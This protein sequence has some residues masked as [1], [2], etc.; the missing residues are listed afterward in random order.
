MRKPFITLLLC[1]TYLAGYSQVDRWQQKVDYTMEIDFDDEKHQYKGKQLLTYTNNS[2]DTLK[3]VFYHLYL[4]AFQPNSM[5]DVRSRTIEDA[6]PR[7][8]DRI[9]KLK[10][11]EVGYQKVIS[12][13]QNKKPV[14]YHVEGTVLEVTLKEPIAPKK[15]AT[16][17]MAFEA[18]V[19][20]QI[21]RT[22]RY[23]KEGVAYSMAQWYPKLAEYDFQGWHA[24][25]YVGREFY[26]VWGDFDVKIKMN[27]DF[28]V[29]ATG[30]IQ[31]PKEVGHGYNKDKKGKPDEDGKLTWHFKAPNVHDFTWAADPD[32]IHKIVKASYGPEMHFFWKKGQGIDD[33]WEKLPDYMDKT[34]KYMN[35][36][37]GEYPYNVYNFVQGGDGGMEYGMLTLVTGQRGL[38]SLVGVSIHELVHSWFQFILATNESLYCWMDEGFDSYTCN[39]IDRDLLGMGE[40]VHEGSYRGYYFIVESGKEEPLNTHSDHF[41]YNRSYGIAAYSKGAIYLHQ[42]SYVVGK[43]AFDRGMK[44]YFNTWKMRH[45]NADDF[46]LIM[47]KESGLQLDWYNEYFV[48]TTK[49]IDYAIKD[50]INKDSR[51]YVTLE[52]LGKMPMPIDLE[53]EYQ[54]GSK[55]V[56]YIPLAIMRG[57]KQSETTLKRTIL[58]DWA[59]THPLYTLEIPQ[60]KKVKYI[61]IDKSKRMADIERTNN[62]YRIPD[63]IKTGAGM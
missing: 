53:I 35:E 32:Y 39:E 1:L 27:K 22:G 43:S 51:T 2:P 11:E 14:K 48:N 37:Y 44:R 34:F 56:F 15:K 62:V 63:T 55:E 17:E 40:G 24:N 28:V 12:L 61:E 60:G 6:D 52:R 5:M 49:T 7:V 26:G 36:R 16:F 46:L 21:R 33:D 18:Q 59:W 25:P 13:T 3:K 30:Y 47:E 45:P 23:N 50:V 42:L 9:S 4:N 8:R 57:E 19:P 31:N 38:N 10:P 58:P 29:A 20:L 54:D 41:E